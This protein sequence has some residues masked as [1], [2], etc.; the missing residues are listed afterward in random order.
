MGLASVFS[1]EAQLA[2]IPA[3]VADLLAQPMPHRL[4]PDRPILFCGIGTSLHAARIAADWIGRATEGRVRSF[5]CDAHDIGTGAVPLRRDDQL[6]VL[7]HRGSKIFPTASLSRARSIG[8]RTVAIVGRGAPEQDADI[9]IRTCANESAG[10]FSVSYLASLTMLARLVA[11]TFPR[12][13]LR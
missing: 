4:N 11:A 5:A 1:Y 7:S 13:R 10:T 9:T 2:S 3:V 8:C 12:K 6:V